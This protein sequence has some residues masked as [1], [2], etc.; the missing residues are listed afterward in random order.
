MFKTPRKTTYSDSRC[1]YESIH[2]SILSRLSEQDLPI[3]L[4]DIAP[5][6]RRLNELNVME[7]RSLFLHVARK[8]ISEDEAQQFGSASRKD[9]GLRRTVQNHAAA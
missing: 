8:W 2:D 1:T 6:A 9:E 4:G 3:Y 5:L 7:A